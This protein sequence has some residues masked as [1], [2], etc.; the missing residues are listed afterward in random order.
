MTYNVK[1]SPRVLIEGIRYIIKFYVVLLFH[2]QLPEG[3]ET[4]SKTPRQCTSLAIQDSWRVRG[5]GYGGEK[6]R[7]ENP[8]LAESKLKSFCRTQSRAHRRL[9][10]L[11][12]KCSQY[13]VQLEWR[14]AAGKTLAT[15]LQT[16]FFNPPK[17]FD[18][19]THLFP[20]ECTVRE[21]SL[22]THFTRLHL[23][24]SACP[25]S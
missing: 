13:Q 25:V 2:L 14:L 9:T 6:R 16:L 12:I 4:I 20:M 19:K 15:L 21:N 7:G 18:S 23:Y 1:L 17:I 5:R 10:H 24:G 11:R 8:S 3:P 22:L